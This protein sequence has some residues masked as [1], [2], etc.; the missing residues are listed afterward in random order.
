MRRARPLWVVSIDARRS[1]CGTS[2]FRPSGLEE[3]R[4]DAGQD[5]TDAGRHDAGTGRW[6]TN[7]RLRS[8]LR[9]FHRTTFTARSS[10]PWVRGVSM[11]DEHPPVGERRVVLLGGSVLSARRACPR[12]G[13]RDR[14][15]ITR[16][17]LSAGHR[18]GRGL[19]L[20]LGAFC[21]HAGVG[22]GRWL[23]GWS[24]KTRPEPARRREVQ[25]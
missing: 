17:P 23:G 3:C 21:R 15:P 7:P 24:S 22:V 6:K 13:R 9:A 16:N 11:I 8:R 19:H 20:A 5:G 12:S 2:P 1:R 18:V 10:Q 4:C 25:G 14:Q